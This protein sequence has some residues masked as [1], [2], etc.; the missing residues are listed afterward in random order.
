MN[1]RFRHLFH[2][3][4]RLTNKL[5]VTV[6]KNLPI[7]RTQQAETTPQ[8][9]RKQQN[10]HNR[11]S[12]KRSISRSLGRPISR[13]PVRKTRKFTRLFLLVFLR[14]VQFAVFLSSYRKPKSRWQLTILRIRSQ[15]IF[16]HVE[17]MNLGTNKSF[18]V[19]YPKRKKNQ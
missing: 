15:R 9:Q 17:S 10:R 3:M 6:I 1:K 5:M 13:L 16:I 19:N 2:V 4:F 8:N 12:K 18:S 7:G 11:V 14:V